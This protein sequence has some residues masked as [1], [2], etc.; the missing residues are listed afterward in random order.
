MEFFDAGKRGRSLDVGEPAIVL[1]HGSGLS[2]RYMFPTALQ[3]FWQFIPDVA[4][5]LCYTAPV[6]LARF[7]G[8][9]A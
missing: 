2:G 7:E 5:T 6:P 1:V 4:H 3:L 9:Y 8:V